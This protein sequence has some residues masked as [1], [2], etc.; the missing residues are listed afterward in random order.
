M[1]EPKPFT[2]AVIEAMKRYEEKFGREYPVLSMP[3]DT[4]EEILAD[5]ER[6]IRLS[7][8]LPK[9]YGDDWT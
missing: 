1:T 9:G 7:K 2:D 5:I 6:R 8:P 4:P 3:Q